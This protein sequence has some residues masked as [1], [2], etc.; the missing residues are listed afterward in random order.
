MKRV[1]LL[2]LVALSSLATSGCSIFKNSFDRWLS[3]EQF[4]NEI[5]ERI[6]PF[7]YTKVKENDKNTINNSYR[8]VAFIFVPFFVVY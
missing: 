7:S 2:G 1:L 6:Q 8:K 3:Y 4:I 5:E